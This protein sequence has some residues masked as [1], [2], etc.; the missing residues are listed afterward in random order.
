MSGFALG[1]LAWEEWYANR[2]FRIVRS[3]R[4]PDVHEVLATGLTSDV[5]DDRIKELTAAYRLANPG[6]TSWSSD[7]F[8]KEMETP[9]WVPRKE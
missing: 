4:V 6:K 8:H 5:A 3:N 1:S 7:L 9:P 2:R